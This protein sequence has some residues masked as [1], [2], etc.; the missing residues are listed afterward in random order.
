MASS[1][2]THRRLRVGDLRRLFRA[3]YGA[4]FPDDDAGREDL[5]ELLKPISLGPDPMTR[6]MNAIEVQA[7]WMS[8]VEADELV[9]YIGLQLP[10]W[11]RR[12]TGVSL[13]KRLIVSNAERERLRLWSIAPCD[14]TKEQMA[15]QR[16]AK[17][18]ARMAAKRRQAGVMPRVEYLAKSAS[19]LKPWQ[20]EGI[21][22]RTWERR[23]SKSVSQVRA[24]QTLSASSHT[25]VTS[26]LAAPPLG[27]HDVTRAKAQAKRLPPKGPRNVSH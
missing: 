21:S 25:C 11:E 12:P 14:M 3:R 6:M 13:G 15:E 7:P 16:K 18:R 23:R 26:P 27:Y 22:R 1:P 9:G 19:R 2:E 24:Q 17:H 5:A 10:L 8:Q 20:A 4:T